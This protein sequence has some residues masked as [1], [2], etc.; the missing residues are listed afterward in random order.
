MEQDAQTG[1]EQ[2]SKIRSE[3]TRSL[4]LDRP[5]QRTAPDAW[6]QFL[7]S[8]DRAFRPAMLL[9]FESVHVHRQFGGRHDI[10]HEDKFPACELCSVAQVEVL[11]QRVVL[12]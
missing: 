6:Q 7:A 1:E 12:P 5:W 2:V 8:L 3:M 11:G 9:R 4:E 10:V